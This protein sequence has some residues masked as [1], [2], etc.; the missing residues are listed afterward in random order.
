M[1]KFFKETLM[2]MVLS[3]AGLIIFSSIGLL[4]DDFGFWLIVFL[5]IGFVIYSLFENRTPKDIR[6]SNKEINLQ[7]TKNFKETGYYETNQE[8]R[9]REK[10]EYEEEQERILYEGRN[11]NYIETG[12]YE[13]NQ[14]RRDRE[15][16]EYEEEQERILYEK[17]EKERLEKLKNS[18][19]Y[20][21]SIRE[22][23]S[24]KNDCPNCGRSDGRHDPKCYV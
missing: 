13:T 1:D 11:V 9:D 12:Y 21:I 17:R 18:H 8:R 24:T 2:I 14:E 22:L 5:F 19:E 4:W 20:Q 16:R 3:I 15:K 7:K 10:R 23:N 6:K